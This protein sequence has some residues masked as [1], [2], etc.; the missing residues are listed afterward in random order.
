[1]RGEGQDPGLDRIFHHLVHMSI[2]VNLALELVQR[3]IAEANKKSDKIEERG[4][5]RQDK[6]EAS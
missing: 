1:M 2:K 3:D 5:D 6:A 4:G